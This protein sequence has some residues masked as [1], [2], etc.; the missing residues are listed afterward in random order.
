M[1]KHLPSKYCTYS[2]Q[3]LLSSPYPSSRNITAVGISGNICDQMCNY[4]YNVD[5]NTYLYSPVICNIM[6]LMFINRKKFLGWRVLWRPNC[7]SRTCIHPRGLLWWCC[8]DPSEKIIILHYFWVHVLGFSINH[9]HFSSK[10]VSSLSPASL[11]RSVRLP[12][13]SSQGLN[14]WLI[15]KRRK[16]EWGVGRTPTPKTTNTEAAFLDNWATSSMGTSF[17]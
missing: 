15:R 13:L 17:P 7:H 6:V 16:I 9:L 2:Y 11:L 12:Q 3:I 14:A 4:Q 8:N 5:K 10:E 1:S